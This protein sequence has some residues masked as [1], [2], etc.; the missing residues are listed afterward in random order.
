M[1]FIVTKP[2]FFQQ[3]Y[4]NNKITRTRKAKPLYEKIIFNHE[5]SIYFI[6]ARKSSG[7][8][9]EILIFK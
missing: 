9:E 7:R 6:D 3:R 2:C 5:D 1:V 8:L 4:Y